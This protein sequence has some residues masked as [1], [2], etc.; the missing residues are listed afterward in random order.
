VRYTPSSEGEQLEL[1]HSIG[2]ER[3]EDLLEGIPE[4]LRMKEPI[5]IPE[6]V[7][8]MEVK[9]RV[10]EYAS[11]NRGSSS[12]VCFAGGGA[13]DHFIPAAVDTIVS[14]SEFTTAYTPYQSEVS[15]GTLQVIY[16]FQSLVAEL[17]GMEVANASLY[18]GGHAL[19]EAMLLAHSTRGIDRAVVS[20]GV[21]PHFRK[22]L[23]TYAAG[24][25]IEV[26]TVGLS[27]S[28]RT[29]ESALAE[30]LNEPACAV[31]LSQ[32]NFFGVLEDPGRL[33]EVIRSDSPKPPLVV[34]SVYPISLGMLSPPGQWGADVATAEGQA[35][36]LPLSLG[37]PYLGLF[38]AS[39]E[40]IRRMP[41]RLIGRTVDCEGRQAFVMTLQTREQHIRRARATSNICTNQGLCATWATVYMTLLGPAGLTEVAQHCWRKAHYL[42][43]QLTAIPGVEMTF[44][45]I[46]FFNEFTLTLSGDTHHILNSLADE[47]F[48]GGVDLKRFGEEMPGDMVVAVTENRT[49]AE[50]ESFASA[51]AQVVS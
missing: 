44:G 30:A 25:G 27:E 23:A 20:G 8:E 48:L 10:E 35:L 12:L 32:P 6:G 19:A 28:G 31:I 17:M 18:D 34:A 47:G 15:Q 22:L 1:L 14:R 38:A 4:H 24:L 3:F 7:S 41:G 51:F 50:I 5:P 16:E 46:P 29:D 11:M 43:G 33:V 40:H 45:D 37:G 36:G 13:Y 21:N 39:T 26:V 2:A 9:A 42:A 49:M